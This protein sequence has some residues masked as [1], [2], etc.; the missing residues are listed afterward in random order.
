MANKIF[1]FHF[2]LL[3]KH[4]ISNNPD[5]TVAV[6]TNG[7]AKILNDIMGGPFD[8]QASP[9]LVKDSQLF[10]GVTAIISLEH[11][12][13]NRVLNILGKD[14]SGILPLD[15]V[16]FQQTRDGLIDYFS[17]FNKHLKFYLDQQVILSAAPYHINYTGRQDWQGKT[18]ATIAAALLAEQE[19]RYLVFSIEGGHNL[20]DVPI[21]GTAMSRTPELN[22]QQLQDRKDVDFLSINLCHLSY[23]PEQPLGGFA[24]G[25]NKVAQVAFSSEDFMPK[26]GLGITALGKKVVKQAL[27]HPDKPILIDV[28]HMSAYT[29]A[30]FY[31]YREQLINDTPTIARLPII[32]SHTGFTFN[33]LGEYLNKKEFRATTSV[34]NGIAVCLV[35]PENK[36]IG[37]TNDRI[38]RGLYSNPWSINLFDEDIVEIMTSKGMIGISLDQRILGADKIIDSSRTQYFEGEYIAKEE[39]ETMFRDGLLPGKEG[40]FDFLKNIAPSRAERHIMLLCMHIVYAVRVGYQNLAWEAGT[41]PWNHICIGSDFDGLINPI[42]R[43]D[44]IA[45]LS[46][47]RDGLKQYIPIADKYLSSDNAAID[48]VRALHYN[49]DGTFDG[50]YLD[51]MIDRF[52]YLNGVDFT[53]R[54]L[55][56][57]H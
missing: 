11:A 33:T 19:K 25:L 15:Q 7:V 37:R 46:N 57:W 23:I 18:A 10:L 28:K 8:S 41:S 52:V 14:F 27:T 24:Q 43:L 30:D 1:D 51:R 20:S 12:F 42:N 35:E 13:A 5:V 17:A 29:R 40:L 50:Q 48:S 26:T 4:Y 32:S 39:W 49:A 36:E 47:L 9:S 54:F 6:R 2:H 55:S 44:N 16:L 31:N 38:N 22:L 56:N 53:A 45:L 34:E 3:F 21:H